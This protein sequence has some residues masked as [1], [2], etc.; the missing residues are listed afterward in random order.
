MTGH[1]ARYHKLAALA[2]APTPARR[3][4]AALVAGALAFALVQL[5][6]GVVWG[7]GWSIVLFSSVA[8]GVAAAVAAATLKRGL[9]IAYGV[10]GALWLLAEVVAALIGCIAAGLG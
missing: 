6:L 2:E 10:F 4:L 3:A 5:L 1:L 9:A 7:A 8:F